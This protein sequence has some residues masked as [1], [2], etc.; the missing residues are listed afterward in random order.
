V[1]C[2]GVTQSDSAF[3]AIGVRTFAVGQ[4]R[5]QRNVAA[6]AMFDFC[7]CER[8]LTLALSSVEEERGIGIHIRI[9]IFEF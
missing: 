9:L 3:R 6:M 2:G 1:E 7:R 8:L 5:R 4:K